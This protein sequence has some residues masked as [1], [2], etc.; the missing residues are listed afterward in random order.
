MRTKTRL[1]NIFLKPLSKAENLQM[2]R[3]CSDINI[4]ALDVVATDQ[5]GD[6]ERYLQA[7]LDFF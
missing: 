4:E 5:E 7:T 2:L 6:W 3:W 1:S